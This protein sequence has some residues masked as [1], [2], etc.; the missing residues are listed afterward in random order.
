VPDLKCFAQSN[1]RKTVDFREKRFQN[2]YP[3]THYED[4]MSTKPLTA[5]PPAELLRALKAALD[6]PPDFVV[7]APAGVTLVGDSFG[8]SDGWAFL[9][10]VN[11]F[12]WLAVR[13]ITAPLVTLRSLDDTP[14]EAA[15]R[16]TE[17]DDRLDLSGRPLPVWA[18]YAAGT[19]WA[20]QDAGLAT[21]GSTLSL[22]NT[23]PRRAGMAASAAMTAAYA[24]A[25]VSVTGWEVE[26]L[27]LAQ[28]CQRAEKEYVGFGPSPLPDYVG[29]FGRA[30]HVM[31]CDCRMHTWEAIIL[32]EEVTLVMLDTGLRRESTGGEDDP[33][34]TQAAEALHTLQSFLP[35]IRTLR[36][37]TLEQLGSHADLLNGN[38]QMLLQFIIE[39]NART[40]AAARALRVSEP[41]VLGEIM[42]ESHRGLRDQAGLVNDAEDLA[43][44]I[45]AE[46]PAR[47]GG[48]AN[49]AGMVLFL[50]QTDGVD[51][52]T[53]HLNSHYTGMTGEPPHLHV[54]ATSDAVRV[55]SGRDL[56]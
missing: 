47:L 33:L 16:L 22:T 36:D 13:E 25:W 11:H 51:G 32:P 24:M 52:F 49:G 29:L 50:V 20:L 18:Q 42:D 54:L 10:T 31:L 43:W 34:R 12:A 19:A 56:I 30:G 23:I 44:Q 45:A 2:V 55:L 17:L 5:R 3:E 48:R 7:R 40:Q 4:N 8:L 9:A 26:K 39:E 27:E 46:H 53:A 35:G 14:G 38:V 37:V 6:G 21:P 41:T 1:L 28:I 15:F